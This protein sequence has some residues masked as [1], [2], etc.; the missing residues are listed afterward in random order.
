MPSTSFSARLAEI[1]LSDSDER[2][3]RLS[4]LW[5]SRPAAIVFLRHY[6]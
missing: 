1:I 4:S 2:P 5:A 6:G 3:V